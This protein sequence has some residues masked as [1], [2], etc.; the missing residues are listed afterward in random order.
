MIEIRITK[1]FIQ[2]INSLNNG[3]VYKLV[4]D[5]E[6]PGR[7]NSFP[8]YSLNY[9]GLSSFMSNEFGARNDLKI[10]K[11]IYIAMDQF[12]RF[13]AVISPNKNIYVLENEYHIDGDLITAKYGKMSS[14]LKERYDLS[15]DE[16]SKQVKEEHR[17]TLEY[18]RKQN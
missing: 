4:D 16:F 18:E 1:W 17:L 15:K 12:G 10:G 11:P 14:Y 13:L 7:Y 8:I 9:D 2:E 6:N 5:I 3:T